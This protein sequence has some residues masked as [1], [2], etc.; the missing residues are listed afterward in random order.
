VRLVREVL[1]ATEGAS[2]RVPEGQE[3]VNHCA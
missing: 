3:C 2:G 1:W